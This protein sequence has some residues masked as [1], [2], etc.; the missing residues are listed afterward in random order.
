MQLLLTAG[1]IQ[2]SAATL[3][4]KAVAAAVARL[5]PD[6]YAAALDRT[7]RMQ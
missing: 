1:K 4:I 6:R 2:D 3:H 5:Q 7:A